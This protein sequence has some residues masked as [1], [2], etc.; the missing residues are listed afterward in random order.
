MWIFGRHRCV[1]EDRL[2]DYVGGRL[3]PEERAR[4]E[5]SL[6]TCA[7]CREELESLQQTR[8]M[9]QALPQE[10]LP[11]SFVFEQAPAPAFTEEY[12]A[13]SV[14]GLRM[15]G[16][17]YAG[18]AAVAG[19]AVVVFVLSGAADS[20]LPGGAA[21]DGRS[22]AMSSPGEA[23]Q[24]A[25]VRISPAEGQAAPEA[26]AE[27]PVPASQSV[28]P[29][30]MV[31]SSVP[32][33]AQ[34]MAEGQGVVADAEVAKA[35]EVEVAPESLSVSPEEGTVV[36]PVAAPEAMAQPVA[37]MVAEEPTAAPEAMAQPMA[38]M[39]V[40]EPTPVA[41]P[42]AAPAQAEAVAAGADGAVVAARA[43]DS[44]VVPDPTAA[45]PAAKATPVG[46]CGGGGGG[47]DGSPRD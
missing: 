28:A 7:R 31:E 43:A 44:D 24:P 41:A 34:A 45:A 2:N 19:L 38:A 20:W 5:R 33:Q 4:L 15:P 11:R 27:V 47:S 21:E 13:A 32:A 30:S 8:A 26:Q 25:T 35:V 40:E 18:A 9:L 29:E 37:A 42:A 23:G 6:A 17:A 39:V 16:W 14:P 46:G 1:S 3:S 10:P 12:R 36:E 22:M